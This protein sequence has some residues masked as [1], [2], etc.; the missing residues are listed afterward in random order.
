MHALKGSSSI[1]Q[2]ADN[3]II[4]H[5]CSRAGDSYETNKV[6]VRVAK[7]RMFGYEG[8]VYLQYCPEWDGYLEPKEGSICASK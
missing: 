2:Y 3:I 1:K 7:N 5:R 4:L 6:K 8:N